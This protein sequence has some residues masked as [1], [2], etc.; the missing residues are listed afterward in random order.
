M[1]RSKPPIIHRLVAALVLLSAFT[2]L[3]TAQEHGP[4]LSPE[5]RDSLLWCAMQ[6]AAAR[7]FY[8]DRESPI[9]PMFPHVP[10]PNVLLLR[11]R[12]RPGNN[13]PVDMLLVY[14]T[15]SDSTPRRLAFEAHDIIVWHNGNPQVR[16]PS[17]PLVALAD[18]IKVACT[19]R[20]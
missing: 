4:L 20:R 17:P 9:T 5:G 8:V 7:Q 16:P 6:E 11:E 2:R 1:P 15:S 10:R 3:G 18:S 14:V 13:Y 12:P 19:R